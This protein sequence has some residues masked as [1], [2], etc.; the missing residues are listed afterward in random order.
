MAENP[1]DE[2]INII[3]SAIIFEPSAGI[4][5][6]ERDTITKSFCDSLRIVLEWNVS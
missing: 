5:D 2:I 3:R 4:G 1:N 6:V